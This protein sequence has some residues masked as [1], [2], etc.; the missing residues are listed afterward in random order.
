MNG[1]QLYAAVYA[2][3]KTERLP[4]HG[5][6]GWAEAVERWRRE[7]LPPDADPNVVLDL[8]ADEAMGLPLN[9]NMVPTFPIRVLTEGDDYVTLVDEYGVTKKVLRSDYARSQGY[10]GA[11]GAMSSMSHWLDFPVKDLRSWKAIYEE[12]FR[13]DVGERLPEDWDA[14]RPDFRKHA[15]TRWVNYFS[16]PFGGL[17]SAVRELMGLPGTLFA[18]HD[19]PELVR[20][21]VADFRRFYL[22]CFEQIL[23]DVRLDGITFFEDM[24]ATKAPLISPSAFREFIAPEYGKLIG[25]LREMGVQQFHMDTDGNAWLIIPELLACG[26]TG[27]SPCEVQSGMDVAA[28]RDAFPTLCM[29]GGIDKRALTKGEAEIDVEL[30]RC[31][32]VAWRAGRYTPGL[33]HGA[34]PDIPWANV[35]HYARGY[36]ERCT[37]C[38]T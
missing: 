9:L 25:G 35:Q 2:G 34:P 30:D 11:A 10:K 17:F 31:F 37:G 15:E 23:G 24:C 3:E 21:M 19:T 4:I 14:Q 18:M 26:F 16:F 33:D 38:G 13:P 8:A 1:R 12:R 22:G 5:V 20:T 32:A 36:L 28:L 7:G 29:N 27:V 6:G